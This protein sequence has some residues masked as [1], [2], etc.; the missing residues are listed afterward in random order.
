MRDDEERAIR[1]RDSYEKVCCENLSSYEAINLNSTRALPL[2]PLSI[3][4]ID[5]A[6]V[7]H[8]VE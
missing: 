1:Q 5:A 6:S 4:I 7:D 2:I 8:N 3:E